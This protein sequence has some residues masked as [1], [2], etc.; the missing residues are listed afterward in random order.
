[1][2]LPQLPLVLPPVVLPPAALDP[3]SITGTSAPCVDSIPSSIP[4]E[5]GQDTVQA[6]R[7]FASR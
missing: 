6:G 4:D 1:L 2:Q 7:F 3:S 5:S